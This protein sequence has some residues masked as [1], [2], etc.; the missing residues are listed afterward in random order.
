[1]K[2]PALPRILVVDDDRATRL[3]RT[4]LAKAGFTVKEAGDGMRALAQLD[5]PRSI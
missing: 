4:I 3:L 1:M 5:T 2:R